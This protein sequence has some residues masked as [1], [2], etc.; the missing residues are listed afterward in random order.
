MDGKGTDLIGAK[1]QR[2]RLVRTTRTGG[3]LCTSVMLSL[4]WSFQVLCL[5]RLQ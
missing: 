1:V 5:L 4:P 2:D 3:L